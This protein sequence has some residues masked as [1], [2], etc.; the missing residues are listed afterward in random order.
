MKSITKEEEEY[1]TNCK[2]IY[3][4]L[5]GTKLFE[6]LEK[7]REKVIHR[8]AHSENDRQTHIEL[9]SLKI[10][11]TLIDKRQQSYNELKRIETIIDEE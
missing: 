3:K 8:I 4:E 5:N 1:Y 9:G 7:L 6:Y 11:D 2:E 10:I